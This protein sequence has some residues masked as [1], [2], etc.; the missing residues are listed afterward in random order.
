MDIESN[1][2][3][4]TDDIRYTDKCDN[5]NKIVLAPDE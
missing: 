4:L 5:D 3:Y 1:F 2:E